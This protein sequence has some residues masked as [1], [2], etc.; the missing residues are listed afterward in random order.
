LQKEKIIKVDGILADFGTSQHQIFQKEGFSFASDSFLDMRMSKSHSRITASYIVNNFSEKELSQLFF[1]LGQERF[2]REISRKIVEE[3]RSKRITM[4]KELADLV[5][6]VVHRFSKTKNRKKTHPATKVFQALRIFV[7]KELDNI[8]MFLNSVIGLIKP[9]GRLVC[10]SFHSL[11]DSIVKKFFKE[12]E[13]EGRLKIMTK[14]VVIAT[15][16]E[17]D[18][19]PSSRSAKMRVAE[20]L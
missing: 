12:K 11:E 1:D 3:R 7:N 4:T 20:Y 17:V 10:I 13:R 18:R 19:N 5:S 14:K 6:S 9:G 8:E 15:E 16:E 2:S